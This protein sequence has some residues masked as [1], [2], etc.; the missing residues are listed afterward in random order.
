MNNNNT[1][2]YQSQFIK[3]LYIFIAVP[4]I[5]EHRSMGQSQGSPRENVST[6]SPIYCCQV[7]RSSSARALSLTYGWRC[8]MIECGGCGQLTVWTHCLC[9]SCPHTPHSIMLHAVPSADSWFSS[10]RNVLFI[11]V[12][13]KA[14]LL[15]IEKACYTLLRKLLCG[16]PISKL[17][18]L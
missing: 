2:T 8:R 3:Y 10:D 4:N 12:K 16:W 14:S 17:E 15:L 7:Q 1:H 9:V 5:L 11:N 6:I 18:F 13:F